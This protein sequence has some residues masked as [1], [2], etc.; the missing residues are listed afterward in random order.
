MNRAC[1][2]Y[3]HMYDLNNE[4]QNNPK[5]KLNKRKTHLNTAN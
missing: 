1:F 2:Q 4:N 5:Q 3:I